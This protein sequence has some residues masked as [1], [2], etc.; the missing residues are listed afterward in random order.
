MQPAGGGDP[1]RPRRDEQ[2]VG[3]AEDQLIA[4]PGD[5]GRLQPSHR[6]LGRQ[7]DKGR[8]LDRPVGGMDDAGASG[9]VTG[10]DLEPESLGVLA[11]EAQAY[12]SAYTSRSPRVAGS[13]FGPC[14]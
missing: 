14:S 7:R 6:P 2:V 10:A 9:P 3:V 1:L 5:L 4:E 12:G 8:S 11:H 13:H